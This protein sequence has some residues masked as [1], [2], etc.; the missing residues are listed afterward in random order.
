MLLC[1]TE[2][3]GLL[4]SG[5]LILPGYPDGKRDRTVWQTRYIKGGSISL[6]MQDGFAVE[7]ERSGVVIRNLDYHAPDRFAVDYNTTAEKQ[8]NTYPELTSIKPGSSVLL[9]SSSEVKLP[10]NVGAIVFGDR[11][12]MGWGIHITPTYY[13]PGFH[14][15]IMVVVSSLS[16]KTIPIPNGCCLARLVL[17][18]GSSD[19][20]PDQQQAVEGLMLPTPLCA[21]S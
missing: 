17:V 19:A 4:D 16:R 7:N 5:D 6:I 12:A 11:N 13:D 8:F 21:V 1:K 15:S 10:V 9:T 20:V 18:M 14:G 2:I 3:V